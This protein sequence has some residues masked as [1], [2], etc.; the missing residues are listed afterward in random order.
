MATLARGYVHTFT[1]LPRRCGG[2]KCVI[3]SGL[4]LHQMRVFCCNRIYMLHWHQ[5][6]HNILRRCCHPP[7][8]RGIST[9][10]TKVVGT[11]FIYP[12]QLWSLWFCTKVTTGLHHHLHR[13]MYSLYPV[14]VAI[15]PR[16][17]FPQPPPSRPLFLLISFFYRERGVNIVALDHCCWGILLGSSPNDSPPPSLEIVIHLHCHM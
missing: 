10:G 11:L 2:R 4:I 12:F 3:S 8:G 13:W 5:C 6:P 14:G 1:V 17:S 7:L 15:L 16:H 9:V